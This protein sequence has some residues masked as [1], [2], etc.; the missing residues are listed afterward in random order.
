MHIGLYACSAQACVTQ[1]MKHVFC[2]LLQGTACATNTDRHT[3]LVNVV[4]LCTCTHPYTHTRTPHMH[5]P[6]T[7]TR[8]HTHA[9]NT[10]TS[11]RTH[12]LSHK[13]AHTRA[14]TR[15]LAQAACSVQPMLPLPGLLSTS[16]SLLASPGLMR[17]VLTTRTFH[18]VALTPLQLLH[19]CRMLSAG[20]KQQQLLYQAPHSLCP[21]SS[22]PLHQAWAVA[23]AMSVPGLPP[24]L[25]ALVLEVLAGY[26]Q[27]HMPQL[28]PAGLAPCSHAVDVEEVGPAWKGTCARVCLCCAVRAQRVCALCLFFSAY[29]VYVCAVCVRVNACA[30]PA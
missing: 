6:S 15:V 4:Y 17:R 14:C 10:H 25:P 2:T 13:H 24:S 5:T 21:S 7:H 9:L 11:S 16:T 19:M 18:K 28:P 26:A 12:M 23:A 20:W 3:R 29:T 8:A 27:A 30:G 22:A 1:C